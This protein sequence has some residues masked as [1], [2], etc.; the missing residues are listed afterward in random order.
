PTDAAPPTATPS[1]NNSKLTAL[2]RAPAPNAS[3]SPI[4]RA[5]HDRASPRSMPSTSDEAATTPQPNAPPTLTRGYRAR[6]VPPVP[7]ASRR[8]GGHERAGGYLP[9]P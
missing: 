8:G 1:S 5:G 7:V 9:P 6:M 2:M 3:T 4:S